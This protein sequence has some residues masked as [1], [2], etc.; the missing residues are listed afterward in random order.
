MLVAPPG[1]E[2][3]DDWEEAGFVSIG[4]G[5]VDNNNGILGFPFPTAAPASRGNLSL[6]IM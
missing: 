6:I 5:S 1:D 3:G 2:D 4:D